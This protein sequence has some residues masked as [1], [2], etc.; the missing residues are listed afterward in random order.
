MSW[1][2]QIWREKR[3]SGNYRCTLI[4]SLHPSV[5]NHFSR[6]FS[7]Q[8]LYHRAYILNLTLSHGFPVSFT[9]EIRISV[10]VDHLFQVRLWVSGPCSKTIFIVLEIFLIS[11]IFKTIFCPFH[12]CFL[13]FFKTDDHS[14]LTSLRGCTKIMTV[15]VLPWTVAHIRR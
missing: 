1:R 12:E 8:S 3:T 5:T 10:H 9:D 4:L 11:C 15:F 7:Y 13:Y 2:I 6:L 14:E